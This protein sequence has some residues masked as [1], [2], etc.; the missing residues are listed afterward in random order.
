MEKINKKKI[1]NKSTNIT[2]SSFKNKEEISIIKKNSV[3]MN[4][5]LKNYENNSKKV[6][7]INVEKNILM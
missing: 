5:D 1:Q 3:K 6:K 2:N 4:F 7:F